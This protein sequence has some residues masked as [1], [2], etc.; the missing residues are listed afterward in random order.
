MMIGLSVWAVREP[1]KKQKKVGRKSQ[2]RD[3]PRLRRAA[4]GD[5]TS[6]KLG[7]LGDPWDVITLAK[8]GLVI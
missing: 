2:S 8:F 6:T 1:G 7:T 5:V 3:K 4:A